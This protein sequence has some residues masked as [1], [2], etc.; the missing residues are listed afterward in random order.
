MPNSNPLTARSRD[1]DYGLQCKAGRGCGSGGQGGASARNDRSRRRLRNI[2]RQMKNRC[3]NPKYRAYARYGGRG[4]TVCQ[5]WLDPET[6]F[7]AFAA[8]AQQNGYREDLSIDR[9]DNNGGYSPENCRWATAREQA[10]NRCTNQYETVAGQT[11]CRAG[12]NRILGLS[13]NAIYD[14]ARR[15]IPPGVYIS[16]KLLQASGQNEKSPPVTAITK[17][18]Q[19]K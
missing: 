4:I 1:A 11:I 16:Q 13:P 3:L 2:W 7:A 12:W 6:G 19:G 9:R 17:A 14:A 8:W 10:Q 5:Q 15:G 18:A